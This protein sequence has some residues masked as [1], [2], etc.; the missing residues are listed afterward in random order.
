MAL[1]RPKYSQIYDTDYKQSVRVATTG[2]VGT[3]LVA[4]GA[5]N[6]VDTVTLILNDR[7]LVKDQTASAQNGIYR[8]TVVGT[9][10][11]GTWIRDH[12]ADA[13]DK[14][15]S[16]LTTTVAEGATNIGRTYKLITSDPI[17]LG[18][19]LLTFTNPFAATATGSDTQVLFNNA[20]L[21][22]GATS[23][24]YFTGN[25]V[26]LASAGVASTSTTT[27]TLQVT[28]G[29]GASGNINAGNVIGTTATFTNYQGT[30][31][32]AS[33]PNVTTLGGV[34]SIGASGTTTLTGILQTAGQ[35][36]VTSLGTLTSL[37]T[38]AITTTGTLALN[39][40]GGLTTNQ[41]TF[42]LA[43]TTATT[44]RLV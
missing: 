19:T 8:V 21:L 28:G 36:N 37:A 18:S 27:G 4:G 17:T 31:L 30:L 41:T 33:Q 34:T 32:T 9:G 10:V 38:G 42:V 3:L 20:T 14:V 11:N 23:L 26:V 40:A 13:S 12:D 7:I 39:A 43:N 2:D 5:P 15:T 24:H 29:I 25:G 6:T 1:T 44:E 35:T 22:A 16:G